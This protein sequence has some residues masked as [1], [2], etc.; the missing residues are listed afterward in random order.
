[1]RSFAGTPV[2]GW[3]RGA[4]GAGGHFRRGHR[5]SVSRSEAKPR[6]PSYYRQILQAHKNNYRRPWVLHP[7]DTAGLPSDEQELSSDWCSY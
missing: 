7:S 6:P 3:G 5:W 1:M 4:R 2:K